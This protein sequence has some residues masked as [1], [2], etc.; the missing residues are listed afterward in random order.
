V[1]ADGAPSAYR[2]RARFSK[3][4]NFIQNAC[5]LVGTLETACL[6]LFPPNSADILRFGGLAAA[7]AFGALVATL[8]TETTFA[9]LTTDFIAPLESGL[10]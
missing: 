8:G 3:P 9:G 5:D 7:G 1:P 10:P 6:G 4:L 2:H